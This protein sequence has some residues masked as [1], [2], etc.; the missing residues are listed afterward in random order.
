MRHVGCLI[1][2]ILKFREV[3][4]KLFLGMEILKGGRLSDLIAKNESFTDIDASKIMKC[5]LNGVNYFH[6]KGIVHRDLKPGKF[7]II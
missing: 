7:P 1:I 3:G 6:S 2:I 4:G 5:I